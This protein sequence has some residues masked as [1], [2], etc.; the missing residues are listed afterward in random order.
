MQ[1]LKLLLIVLTLAITVHGAEDSAFR[2]WSD[3]S[4]SFKLEAQLVKLAGDSVTLRRKDGKEITLPLAKLSK[5]DQEFLKNPAG[6]K[7]AKSFDLPQR[8]AARTLGAATLV[9]DLT[10]EVKALPAE[11][12]TPPMIAV[13]QLGELAADPMPGLMTAKPFGVAVVEV[14]AYDKF[15]RPVCIDSGSG[16]MIVSIGRRVAGQTVARGR[17]YRMGYGMKKA[18]LLLDAEES[19]DVVTHDLESG[20]TLLIAGRDELYRGGELVLIDGLIDGKVKVICRRSLPGIEK[21]GF[22]PNVEWAALKNSLAIVV[23]DSNVYGWDLE[24]NKLVYQHNLNPGEKTAIS[25]GGKYLAIGCNSKVILLD[26]ASGE[27][28]GQ[29]STGTTLVPQLAFDPTGRQLAIGMDNRLDV[30]NLAAA[31]RESQLTLFSP[32]GEMLGWV[33]PGLLLTSLAG[34]VDL[35]L[36]MGVWNYY[37]PHADRCRAIESGLV[38]C[39]EQKSFLVVSVLTVPHAPASRF[40]ARLTGGAA[41]DLIVQPGTAVSIRIDTKQSVDTAAIKAAMQ[42]IAEKAG[43]TVKPKASIELVA[44]IGRGEKQSL[45]YRLSQGT[46]SKEEIATITPFTSELQIQRGGKVLWNRQTSNHVPSILFL[47]DGQT[48]QQEVSK[49]EKPDPTFFEHLNLPPRIINPDAKKGMGQ[50][51]LTENGWTE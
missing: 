16:T 26:A 45:S 11:E 37:L 50:S 1:P 40:R 7:T 19:V 41:K 39:D 36:E 43:W 32:I 22:K 28:L 42:T 15:S 12:K 23:V 21:P 51:R 49:Y 48:V 25:P 5:G 27:P 34:L 35:E 2:T 44:V 33:Q 30:W 3:A 4:G 14:D 29:F 17:I 46:N 13:P 31:D 18:E 9:K 10:A 6:M 47:R 8:S 38:S 24:E 20:R